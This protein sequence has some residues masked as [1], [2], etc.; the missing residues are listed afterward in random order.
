VCNNCGSIGNGGSSSSGG[1]NRIEPLSFFFAV[2]DVTSSDLWSN[3]YGS[4]YVWR[5]DSIKVNEIHIVQ[6]VADTGAA[7]P[8]MNIKINGVTVVNAA[9]M[10]LNASDGVWST[11]AVSGTEANTIITDGD[12]IEFDYTVGTLSTSEEIFV[13]L[14]CV[15]V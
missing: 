15:G 2:G 7:Q 13:N 8:V 1:A 6:G 4:K 3:K 12:T 10:T 14:E 5:G 11:Y 9:A